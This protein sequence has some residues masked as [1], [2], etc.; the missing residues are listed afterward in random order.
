MFVCAHLGAE[1]FDLAS[2][3]P[4][5]FKNLVFDYK[6]AIVGGHLELPVISTEGLVKLKVT[7]IK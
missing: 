5:V 1:D 6:S 4:M 3:D 7:S 2:L